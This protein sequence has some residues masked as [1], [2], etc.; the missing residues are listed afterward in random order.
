MQALYPELMPA[1]PTSPGYDP[2]L[3][4]AAKEGR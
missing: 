2:P 3:A 4:P 1:G